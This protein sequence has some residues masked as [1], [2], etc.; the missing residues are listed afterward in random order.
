MTRRLIL[1]ASPAFAFV[2]TMGIVN[3]FADVTY[4]GGASINGPFLGMLGASAAMISIVA[5]AGEFC[6]YAL[7]LASGYLADTTGTLG[8]GWVYA[9]NTALDET[10]ATLGPLL[11]ALVLAMHGS[12]RTGYAVLLVPAALALAALT[13]ARIIFPLPARLEVGRTAPA[14]RFTR[15]YWLY[16]LAGTF[17]DAGLGSFELIS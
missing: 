4:E 1:G 17:F 9:V 6:G 7:R 3:L 14:M 11:V 15:A 12:Y 8:T 16:M 5:G 2:L 10:G 13:A